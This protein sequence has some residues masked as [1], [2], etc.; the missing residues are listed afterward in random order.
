MAEATKRECEVHVVCYLS[1]HLLIQPTQITFGQFWPYGH[2][3]VPNKRLNA[4]PVYN[5]PAGG[6]RYCEQLVSAWAFNFA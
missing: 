1:S 3:R 2:N 5:N 4:E 6:G